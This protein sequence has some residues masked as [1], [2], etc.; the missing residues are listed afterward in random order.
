MSQSTGNLYQQSRINTFT[1]ENIIHIGTVTTKFVCEPR[2][3]TTLTVEFFFYDFTNMYH[4]NKK[5]G[6]I[7]CLFSS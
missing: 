6:T 4:D 1:L 5:G 3:R 2:N 7:R